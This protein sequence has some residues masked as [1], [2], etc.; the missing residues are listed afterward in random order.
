MDSL[1][2]RTMDISI[3]IPLFKG[4]KFCK[5]L[6]NMVEKNCL[7]HN[8]FKKCTIEILFVNDYPGEKIFI[9]D[10]DRHFSIRIISQK[11]NMGIHASRVKGIQNAL[12][13]YV[14]MLD[15]DDFV[16][17]AWLYSQWH[18]II[19]DHSDYCVCNGWKGRFQV[20]SEP[21]RFNMVISDINYYLSVKNPICSPGQVIL[22]KRSIPQEW[23][24]N[25][26]VYN[27][28][29]DFFL[30]LLALK[31]GWSFSVNDEYLYY[32][33]PERNYDSINLQGMIYSLKETARLLDKIK[34]LTHDEM[35][36]LNEQI[37]KKEHNDY[38]KF[39]KMFHIMLDW[40][41]LKNKGINI[42]NYLIK[43]N[44]LN[45]A[46]YGMGYIGEYLYEELYGTD[47]NVRYGIDYSSKDRNGQ[48]D[49]FRIT[50]QLGDVDAIIITISRDEKEIVQTIV[51][52]VA[53]PVITISDILLELRDSMESEPGDFIC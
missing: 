37:H 21:A 6:L 38:I 28:S 30:W 46:I 2:K 12:G 39:Q 19:S 29:D 36:L 48:L 17:D 25:I 49:I 13:E 33:T 43:N 15:Q 27:G 14:I 45:I 8:L 32:H 9:E 41:K 51:S 35:N 3:I 7:Y 11:R 31:K 52:K 10:T 18:K 53:C 1:Q 40:I 47:V 23:L 16:S 24:E 20:I 50:D 22:R 44:Y 42:Y 5:R 4:Q 34:L 26:Q